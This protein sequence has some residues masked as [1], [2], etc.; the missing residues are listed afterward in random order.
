MATT[1]FKAS[2]IYEPETLRDERGDSTEPITHEP[3][4]LAGPS[5]LRGDASSDGSLGTL[6]KSDEHATLSSAVEYETLNAKSSVKPFQIQIAKSERPRTTLQTFEGVVV[7]V[8][9]DEFDV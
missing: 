8:S 2:A 6:T 1:A 7:S 4:L 5:S 9:G 3:F